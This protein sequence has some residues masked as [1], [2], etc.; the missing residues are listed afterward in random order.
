MV[1]KLASV[2][3]PI[4]AELLRQTLEQAGIRTLETQVSPHAS[5]AGA[6]SCYYVEVNEQQFDEATAVLRKEGLEKWLVN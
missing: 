2:P 5:L 3:D 6:D 4:Q 1:K